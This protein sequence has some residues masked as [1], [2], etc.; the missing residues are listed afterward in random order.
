[1][2]RK[3]E[4]I[5]RSKHTTSI[6]KLSRQ[7]SE[8]TGIK[9][10]TCRKWINVILQEADIKVSRSKNYKPHTVTDNE[11]K[12]SKSHDSASWEYHGTKSIRTL[13]QALD[14]CEADLQKW[15]VERYIFNSWDVSM[16]DINGDPQTVTNYQVKVWFKPKFNLKLNK[17]V[18]KNVIIK[19]SK[20]VQMWI[21][22]GCVHRPFH[23]QKL[24]NKFLQF[25]TLNRKRINGIIINGDY[26]D[27]LSLNSHGT[28]IPDGL[29]LNV[30]YNSGNKGI[31]EIE[32]CL[33]KGVKKVFHYGNHEDRFFR[34]HESLRKFGA[35]LPAPHEAMKLEEKKWNVITDWKNGFSTL[36]TSLDIFHGTKVGL[37]AAKSEL[38]SLPNRSAIFNHTHRFQSYSHRDQI[39]YNIGW[40]GDV[41]H[42]VFKY[43][44]RGGRYRWTN[45]FAVVYIDDKGNHFV[46]PIKCEDDRF[47]FEGKLF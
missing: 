14:Y 12:W 23:N 21:V 34:D 36:G 11:Q 22:I 5:E 45:G 10:E 28:P 9:V 19:P 2:E 17:V 37:N 1:M 33:K 20:S 15:E 32:S 47:F 27:L 18:P 3:E 43:M 38:D 35:S 16:K 31:I 30:E 6:R 25:L 29:D 44:D 26:L 7:Y 13:E 39:A 41:N 24:W 46:N 4:I 40:F 42:D 8:Q